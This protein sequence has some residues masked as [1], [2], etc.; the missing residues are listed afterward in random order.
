MAENTDRNIEL[1][2]IDDEKLIL[3]GLKRDLE[4]TGYNVSA[5]QKGEDALEVIE[6]VHFSAA[7]IDV[8]LPGMG[9]LEIL[10]RIKRFDPETQVI[11]ITAFADVETAVESIRKGA[12]DFVLKPFSLEK[13]HLSIQN[14]LEAKRLK[15]E[16]ESLKHERQ[17]RQKRHLI[18]GKSPKMRLMIE[19]IEKIG[20]AGARVV[21]LTGESGTGKGVAASDLHQIGPRAQGP[22]IEINCGAIPENLFESELFGY[23]KGA[24]TGASETKKGLMEL[25]DGGTI[26]LDEVGEMPIPIQ[27]KFLKALEDQ[28]IWRIGGRKPI[29]LDISIIAATNRDLLQCVRDEKF[30]EDLF[31]RLNV[32]P[33][34][35]PPLRER[36]EDILVL[37]EH[38]LEIYQVIYKRKFSGFSDESKSF[39]LKYSW[40]GNVREL[41]NCV[42][43]GV[44][45]ETEDIISLPNL[46]LIPESQKSDRRIKTE[47]PSFS[48]IPEGGFDLL[49]HLEETEKKYLTKALTMS[50]G[51]QSQAA[52]ILGMTRD[53]LRYRLKKY[54]LEAIG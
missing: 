11:M 25:A 50:S 31:Y 49:A 40:P 32:I 27:V 46:G 7:L 21:L 24:F 28:K 48:D 38:F 17:Q 5:F 39:I 19:K 43:R 10:E 53:I 3:W 33:I 2:I 12:F 30:R 51:N 41:K 20:K 42:E 15:K 52:K 45:L 18:S 9:G 44:I 6:K 26:F 29:Q 36:E 37:A 34:F 1:L 22:F 14:A 23:E 54:D 16:V 4:R 35:I 13:I 8:R 47:S